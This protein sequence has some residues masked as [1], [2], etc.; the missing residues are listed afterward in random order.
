MS[1]STGSITPGDNSTLIPG[2][3]QTINVS[4][5]A[6]LLVQFN[7]TASAGS[8]ALCGASNTWIDVMLDGGRATRVPQDLANGSFN[9][10]S[11]SWLL[12]VGAGTHTV[13]INALSVGPS[14]TFALAGLTSISNLIIQVIPQ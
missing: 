4:G 1:T 7:V 13:A 10:L 11:G 2:L 12:T 8:C 6:K 14:V 3:S 9:T 5:N